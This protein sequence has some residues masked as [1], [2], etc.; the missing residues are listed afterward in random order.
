MKWRT[1]S[2]VG[3]TLLALTGTGLGQVLVRSSGEE[4]ADGM[5]RLSLQLDW[6]IRGPSAL[7]LE[8]YWDV[9]DFRLIGVEAGE[10]LEAAGKTL[11]HRAREVGQKIQLQLLAAGLNQNTIEP[12]HVVD[13]IV[14]PTGHANVSSISLTRI[15]AADRTG[16]EMQAAVE[17]GPAL[18][19]SGEPNSR[20]PKPIIRPE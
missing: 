7:Q 11:E 4:R 5:V 9:A 3:V 17:R 1:C 6:S 18:R 15:I 13:L 20:Q 2:L 12:G 14:E 10:V 16:Q 8:L 19:D